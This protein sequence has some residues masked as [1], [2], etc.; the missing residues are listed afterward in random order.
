MFSIDLGFFIAAPP[1]AAIRRARP[2]LKRAPACF[3][4]RRPR[5]CS[6]FS[7][8][9]AAHSWAGRRQRALQLLLATTDRCQLTSRWP[10]SS[11]METGSA[12]GPVFFPTRILTGSNVDLRKRLAT[13][14]IGLDLQGTQL[15]QRIFSLHRL[16]VEASAWIILRCRVPRRG[17]GA[18]KF[19]HYATTKIE[20]GDRGC[21]SPFRR[22]LF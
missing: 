2:A 7:Y 17:F 18:Q 13:S 4:P 1:G 6:C 10:L 12:F 22:P 20:V 9:W 21:F 5:F 15:S 11:L 3:F 8:S 16:S 14:A 19:E